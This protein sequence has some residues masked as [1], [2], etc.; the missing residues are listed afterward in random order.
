MPVL[1]MIHEK[2]D[3]SPRKGTW[4]QGVRSQA[5][6]NRG[7][8]KEKSVPSSQ[9]EGPGP[10]IVPRWVNEG[11]VLTRGTPCRC[12]WG[13]A[14]PTQS[15]RSGHL[16]PK[17]FNE[18]PCYSWL[19]TGKTGARACHLP[20]LS[21]R[22]PER[23]EGSRYWPWIDSDSSSLRSRRSSGNLSSEW[24][25]MHCFYGSLAFALPAALGFASP[26]NRSSTPSCGWGSAKPTLQSSWRTWSRGVLTRGT[27]S[28][29]ARGTLSRH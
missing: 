17:W 3:L 5:S 29:Y 11:G 16:V 18:G 10:D 28:R 12:G 1:S 15:L 14:K 2:M 23:S 20:L 24:Q 7:T 8:W 4:K 27:P 9:A 25:A 19:V 22:I 26:Q 6:G 21:S 13:S